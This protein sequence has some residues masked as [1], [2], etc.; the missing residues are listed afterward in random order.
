MLC[1]STLAARQP[2]RP[3]SIFPLEQM[4]SVDLVAPATWPAYD[5]THAYVA[6]RDGHLVAISLATG[7]VR[8]TVDQPTQL[9]PTAGDRSVFV[10]SGE[11]IHA[12][13]TG[14]GVT[15]WRMNLDSGISAP[16]LWDTGW[17]IAA[18]ENGDLLALRG[19]D[20]LEIW[21]SQ[22]ASRVR[23]TPSIAG[24]RVFVPLEDDRVV[25]LDLNSGE[26]VWEQKL[27]GSPARVLA[28]DDLFV[29]STDNFFYCLSQKDGSVKWR[30]RTGADIIGLA[31]VD[32][33]R[34]YFLSLDNV[35]R[36]LDR[37]TGVQRWTH[38]VPT[39]AVTGPRPAGSALLVSGVSPEIRSYRLIDGK[40]AGIYRAPA[41]LAAPAHVVGHPSPEGPHLVILTGEGQLVGLRRGLGPPLAALDDHPGQLVLEGPPL[42]PLTS[43][44]G[45]RLA[46]PPAPGMSRSARAGEF[47]VQVA[48]LQNRGRASALTQELSSH[49]YPAY[50]LAQEPDAA[51]ALYRVRIG[52]YRDRATADQLARRLQQEEQLETSVVQVPPAVP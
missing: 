4:W 20:G 26:P 7:Q 1:L 29:G 39:R 9:P 49:G 23:V 19:S 34:V 21:R 10:A 41:E 27:G 47:T 45:T 2:E 33:D 42:V 44:P 17:L 36:A 13:D 8:W 6:L 3:P 12:L 16:L 50:I 51:T 18:L 48:A 40:P 28:L 52:R 22:L 32:E 24:Q 46:V 31:V 11:L 30:W 5:A 25:A 37:D 14:S 38:P 15:R 35:L 43:L